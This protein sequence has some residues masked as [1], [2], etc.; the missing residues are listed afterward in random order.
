MTSTRKL[1]PNLPPVAVTG[2]ALRANLEIVQQQTRRIALLDVLG[3][4]QRIRPG[5][6]GLAR[7]IARVEEM[8]RGSGGT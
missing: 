4:L 2:A 6:D 7:A 1:P 8:L 5:A 3:E